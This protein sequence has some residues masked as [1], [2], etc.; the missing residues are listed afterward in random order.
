M[1]HVNC[2]EVP[3]P[4]NPR[5]PR[6]VGKQGCWSC[7]LSERLASTVGL[8]FGFRLAVLGSWGV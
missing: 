1:A 2:S 5:M 4:P 3:W 7:A 6:K 8:A